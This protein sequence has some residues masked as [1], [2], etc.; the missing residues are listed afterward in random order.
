MWPF[1][2]WKRFWRRIEL[3]TDSRDFVDLQ[4]LIE[5]QKRHPTLQYLN[6]L[7]MRM[8]KGEFS[9]VLLCS[10]RP[11]PQV[12]LVPGTKMPT[13]VKVIN[14]LKVMTNLRLV[15]CRPP[16][17]GKIELTI[18]GRDAVLHVRFNDTAPDRSVHL[19][20]EWL[21]EP[22]PPTKLG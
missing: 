6:G 13:F 14:R 22:P 5:S 17:E 9:E 18:H 16:K 8:S 20:L 11:L 21:D 3:L 1:G 12:E 19:R 7:L 15:I 2:W 4:E 10:S